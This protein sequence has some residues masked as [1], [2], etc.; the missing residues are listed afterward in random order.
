MTRKKKTEVLALTGAGLF[1]ASIVITARTSM[2]DV[3]KGIITGIAIGL[4][5]LSL[6]LR[7]RQ[8]A[9]S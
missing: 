1:A 9:G 7:S 6:V 4:L 3:S 5:A 8:K 2:T